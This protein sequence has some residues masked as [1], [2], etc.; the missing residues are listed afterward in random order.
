MEKLVDVSYIVSRLR[1]LLKKDYVLE[2]LLRDKEYRRKVLF[3]VSLLGLEDS[4]ISLGS[5]EQV[6]GAYR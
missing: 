5:Q 2:N 6:P 4:L 3:I 1:E